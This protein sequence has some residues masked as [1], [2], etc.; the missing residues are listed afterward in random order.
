MKSKT[1]M[2][3]YMSYTSRKKVDTAP[4]TDVVLKVQSSTQA[5]S[6]PNRKQ[7]RLEAYIGALQCWELLNWKFLDL[8]IISPYWRFFYFGNFLDFKFQEIYK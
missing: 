5:N 2:I 6:K 4:Y 1:I 7:F 8:A 3:Q